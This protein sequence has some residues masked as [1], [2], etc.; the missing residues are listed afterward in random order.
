VINC[1]TEEENLPKRNLLARI[2][3]FK[4]RKKRRKKVF[5]AINKKGDRRKS[6]RAIEAWIE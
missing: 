3:G 1:I 4:N 2:T 6:V 5:E